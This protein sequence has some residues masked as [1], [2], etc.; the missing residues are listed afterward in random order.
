GMDIKG[1][2][3][4]SASDVDFVGPTPNNTPV[5]PAPI[6]TRVVSERPSVSGI[7]EEGEDDEGVEMGAASAGAGLTGLSGDLFAGN[8]RLV[9]MLQGKLGTLLGRSSGYVE[10][11]P[12]P[13]RRRINGLK[14]LQTKHTELECEFHKEILELEK[15]YLA[16]YRPLYEKRADIVHGKLEPTDEEVAAGKSDAEDEEA[17][18]AEEEEEDD[19]TPVEAGIPEFWLTALKNHAGLCEL[20]TESDE[21]PLQSLRDIKLQY[22]DDKPG[23]TIV[24]EFGEN[25][26]F[27]NRTLTKTYY[28]QQSSS[29]G[30]LVYESSRGCDIDWKEG[31]DLTVTIETKKQRHKTTNKTRVI[32]RA[33][34]NE[35]FFSFFSTIQTPEDDTELEDEEQEDLDARLEADYELGEEFKERI[36]PHAVDWFT[37]KALQYENMDMDDEEGLYYGGTTD[38]DDDDDSDD[39]DFPEHG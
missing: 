28:Y 23:F 18:E 9:N 4:A 37:G 22:T 26:F 21:E 34:P 14:Y 30:D 5:Q 20:I 36:I 3:R 29:F 12:A 7:A 32:K 27:T 6:A 10:G 24:F 11:L 17:D 15:K 33:V 25:E 13:I 31:K 16:L 38:D 2:A 19:N 1:K 35:T 8:Q 39:D